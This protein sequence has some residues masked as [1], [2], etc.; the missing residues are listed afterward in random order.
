MKDKIKK[1]TK[2]FKALLESYINPN[3]VTAL[4]RTDLDR[5]ALKGEIEGV[6]AVLLIFGVSSEE[7]NT[8]IDDCHN[9]NQTHE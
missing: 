3:P 5:A 6:E 1:A 2:L 4:L 7:I 9:K 8:M